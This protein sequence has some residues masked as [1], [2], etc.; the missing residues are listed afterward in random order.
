T[1]DSPSSQG[2]AGGVAPVDVEDDEDDIS[3]LDELMSGEEF[4]G[5][6]GD[7]SEE[8]DALDGGLSVDLSVRV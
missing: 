2:G 1:E 5:V 8:E 3:A 7:D 6:L 4:A